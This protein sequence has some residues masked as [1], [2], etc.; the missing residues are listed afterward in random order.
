MFTKFVL[1]SLVL[2]AV[3]KKKKK[4]VSTFPIPQSCLSRH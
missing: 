3:Q 1:F 4:G 2:L